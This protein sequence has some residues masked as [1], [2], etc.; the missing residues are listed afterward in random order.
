MFRARGLQA[1][2]ASIRVLAIATAG[3]TAASGAVVAGAVPG[4]TPASAHAASGDSLEIDSLGVPAVH[5]GGN[6]RSHGRQLVARLARTATDGYGM[7]AV[8]WARGTA[9]TGT[10]VRVRSEV[11]GAWTPWTKVPVDPDEGPSA[12]EEVSGVR[13]GT[14][15]LWVGDGS[16]VAV[17]VTAPAGTRPKHVRVVTIDPGSDPATSASRRLAAAGRAPVQPTK[18]PAM[19]HVITRAQWGADPSLDD[20]CWKPIYGSSAKMVFVHHTVNSNDYA[21]SDGKAIVRAIQAYH[22][23]SRGWCDIGYNFLIDKYGKVYEGRRGGMRRPV[24]GAHAGDYNTNTVGVS[25]IGNFQI[26]RP[27]KQMK[28]ALIRFIGWR[29]GTSYVPVRGTVR[30]NGTQFNRISGHRDAMPTECPGKYVYR[31]L[32]TLRERVAHYLSDYRSSIRVRAK[33]LGRSVT[34]PVFRGEARQDGGLHTVFGNGS[35]YAKAGV[36]AH[37]L[38]GPALRAYQLRG[39]SHGR[40]GF[41]ATD[42]QRTALPRVRLAVF[43]HG[44]MYRVGKQHTYTLWGRIMIRYRKLGG[45]TGQLGPPTSNMLPTGTGR[46]AEFVHGSIT[47]N[48]DTGDVT[49]ESS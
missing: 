7:V 27:T 21:R 4:A 31:W 36:G 1:K 39:G 29:L 10:R 47:W 12:D 42:L 19:P 25:L 8:T 13:D 35:M 34:G 33:D 6:S 18:F 22:T 28:R 16:A 44:R 5:A 45:I 37:W 26:A 23:Q 15:P 14:A 38:T 9:P 48:R 30:V 32:P 24:R 20:P 11:D 2:R 46:R 49:V 17:R 41:P 3:V 43:E 40:F